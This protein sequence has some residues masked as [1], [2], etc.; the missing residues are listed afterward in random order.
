MNSNTQTKALWQLFVAGLASFAA[1][2]AAI[3][4]LLGWQAILLG[5]MAGMA[6]A[7]SVVRLGTWLQ[8][9]SGIY[10]CRFC[11]KPLE[12]PSEACDC[13]GVQASREHR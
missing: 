10:R 11:H 1:G 9:R 8:Y 12:R 2:A 3:L 7:V 6:L 5:I 4:A 13:P